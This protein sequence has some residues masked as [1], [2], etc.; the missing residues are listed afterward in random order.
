MVAAE[1][2]WIKIY[3]YWI[4]YLISL[5]VWYFYLLFVSKKIS[6]KKL[7]EFIWK[8]IDDIIFVLFLWILLWWRIWY[9]LFY[10]LWYFLSNP[11]KIFYIWN[12]GMSFVWGSIWV[13]LWVYFFLKY[14]WFSKKDFLYFMDI[15]VWFVPFGITIWRL[16]NFL[17]QELY[18]RVVTSTFP[19]LNSSIINFLKEINLVHIYTE[20]DLNLRINSNLFEWFGEWFLIFVILQFIFWKYYRFWKLKNGFISGLFLVLYAVIRFVAE[21]LR[22]YPASEYISLLTKSQY[23]MIGFLIVWICLL[24]R[25][26]DN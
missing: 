9:V 8:N 12:G 5:V 26:N 18:W 24:M 23:M 21:M 11:L 7:W 1:I 3:W 25:K 4:F 15:I 14:K 17:N 6:N 16:W 2:F 20:V 13:I 19:G 10:D 22:D